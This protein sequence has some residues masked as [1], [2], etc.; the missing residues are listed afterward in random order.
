ML[1]LLFMPINAFLYVCMVYTYALL[2]VYPTF[3]RCAGVSV[4]FLCLVCVAPVAPNFKWQRHTEG[5]WVLAPRY[6]DLVHIS[7]H[8]SSTSNEIK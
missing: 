3:V 2:R 1:R 7:K 6:L 5:I 4:F 8:S